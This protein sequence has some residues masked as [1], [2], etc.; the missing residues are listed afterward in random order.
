MISESFD[1]DF[2][3]ACV[4]ANI[5][6]L[7]FERLAGEVSKLVK[8]DTVTGYYI[9]TPPLPGLP[10]TKLDIFLLTKDFI[11]NYEIT[12]RD[13]VWSI[14]PLTSVS[15]IRE[16]GL[17]NNEYWSLDISI[18]SSSEVDQTFVLLDNIKN[19]DSIRRFASVLR[20]NLTFSTKQDRDMET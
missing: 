4:D 9:S 7:D 14:V 16:S 1:E 15:H 13:D 12:E 3:S 10:E 11:Y 18:K 2:A 6:H 19:K 8:L 5:G 20:D 17:Q